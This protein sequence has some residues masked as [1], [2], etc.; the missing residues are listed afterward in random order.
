[1]TGM[2]DILI[3]DYSGVNLL[4]VWNTVQDDLPPLEA[5]VEQIIGDLR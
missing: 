1:M 2:R 5:Q 3:H 4:V